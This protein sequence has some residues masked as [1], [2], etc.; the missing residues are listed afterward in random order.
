[1]A[2]V[3]WTD[4]FTMKLETTEEERKDLK[5]TLR[6]TYMIQNRKLETLKTLF[7]LGIEANIR[8]KSVNERVVV[9]DKRMDEMYNDIQRL[10]MEVDALKN[11]YD[12]IKR[13]K[14]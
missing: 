5:K 12:N 2:K 9:R 6:D 13:K 10:D 14:R 8:A 1:M 7:A 4:A 3:V 11:W